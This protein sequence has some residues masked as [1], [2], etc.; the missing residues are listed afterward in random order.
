[1]KNK[2]HKYP[3][4]G[5]LFP[6]D[7]YEHE[8]CDQCLHQPDKTGNGYCPVFMLQLVIDEELMDL[9]FPY[10]E[11]G[12]TLA[13]CT[14]YVPKNTVAVADIEELRCGY[15]ERKGHAYQDEE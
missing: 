3:C 10:E 15:C 4:N 5:R 11:D 8:F 6:P 1:M 14:V 9:F 7:Q 2:G 12:E 13:Q